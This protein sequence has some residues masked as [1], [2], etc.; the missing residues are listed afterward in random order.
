MQLHIVYV[1]NEPNKVI[2]TQKNVPFKKI[3]QKEN[4]HDLRINHIKHIYVKS[5]DE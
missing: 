5:K 3:K 1:K 4:L 2:V